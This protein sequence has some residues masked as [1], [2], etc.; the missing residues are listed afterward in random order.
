V[1]PDRRARDTC[2]HHP[3]LRG[4]RAPAR[5]SAAPP[6][7]PQIAGLSL[8]NPL[9]F[10]RPWGSDTRWARGSFCGFSSRCG[11]SA[12]ARRSWNG[13]PVPPTGPASDGCRSASR[14][15]RSLARRRSVMQPPV[16]SW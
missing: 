12:A 14:H 3:R 2:A 4:L 7:A 13:S 10:M 1:T 16:R 5:C 9:G 8:G 11:A 6:D 15:R